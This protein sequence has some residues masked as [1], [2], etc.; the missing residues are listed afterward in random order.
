MNILPDLYRE[1][2]VCGFICFMRKFE[3]NVKLR[4]ART[5]SA[6]V[7]NQGTLFTWHSVDFA[8][9]ISVPQDDYFCLDGHYQQS[10]VTPHNLWGKPSVE[11]VPDLSVPS[12]LPD[13]KR[14][15]KLRS[16]AVPF[17]RGFAVHSERVFSRLTVSESPI[18]V[19]GSRPRLKSTIR[20]HVCPGPFPGPPRPCG[21]WCTYYVHKHRKKSGVKKTGYWVC[22]RGTLCPNMPQAMRA[23]FSW[24]MDDLAR[25]PAGL[26]PFI[27]PDREQR[28]RYDFF[29]DERVESQGPFV[30]DMRFH[31]VFVR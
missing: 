31:P 14:E 26:S 7:C 27:W 19:G 4:K 12:A 29:R 24:M 28:S 5:H 25:L 21:G 20:G 22:S 16:L 1:P 6:R 18:I 9:V 11:V 10:C 3:T 23:D 13:Q 30:L 2:P 17:P 8:E 15:S